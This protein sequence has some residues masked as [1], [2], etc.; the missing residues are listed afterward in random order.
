MAAKRSFKQLSLGDSGHK[1]IFLKTGGM[2]W[3]VCMLGVEL[4]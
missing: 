2:K 4:G 1:K 3:V